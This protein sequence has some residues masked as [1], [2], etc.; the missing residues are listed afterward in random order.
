MI[1]LFALIGGL[2]AFLPIPGTSLVLIALEI[3][4]LY[5]IQNKYNAFDLV[6]FIG[7][8]AGLAGVS[9]ILKALAASL[10]LIPVIGWAVSAFIAFGFIMIFGN[11]ADGHYSRLARRSN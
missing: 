11:I 4:L 7:V 2:I 3:F 8:S 6:S 5:K 1:L 10:T 9:A